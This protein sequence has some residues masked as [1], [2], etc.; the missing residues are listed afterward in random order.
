MKEQNDN[1]LRLVWEALAG[2][3]IA[4]LKN[5]PI[6]QFAT[7]IPIRGSLEHPKLN[8]WDALVAILHNAFVEA[9]KPQLEKASTS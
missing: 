5:H 2:D 6:D 4:I 3:V 1:P 9:F 8:R 7:R